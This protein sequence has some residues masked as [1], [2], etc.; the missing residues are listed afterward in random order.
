MLYELADR[1]A[2]ATVVGA[3]ELQWR[4]WWALMMFVH[5]ASG[6]DGLE[7]LPPRVQRVD[8]ARHRELLVGYFVDL[9]L[10][11]A[12]PPPVAADSDLF[13]GLRTWTV[14]ELRRRDGYVRVV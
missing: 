6:L 4:N 2:M 10:D 11:G 1:G 3:H 14:G 7:T 9:E 5:T 12:G 8:L 13:G